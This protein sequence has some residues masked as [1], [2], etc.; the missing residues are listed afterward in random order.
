MLTT[1][2]QNLLRLIHTVGVRPL[3]RSTPGIRKFFDNRKRHK[4]RPC[5]N[6][7]KCRKRPSANKKKHRSRLGLW[8]NSGGKHWPRKLWR[9][10]KH[11]H[12]RCSGSIL[13]WIHPKMQQE[14]TR[15]SRRHLDLHTR[16]QGG[17]SPRL[18][19][20]RSP[21]V[22][23]WTLQSRSR[24]V[25]VRSPMLQHQTAKTRLSPDGRGL[26]GVAVVSEGR[27]A[28]QRRHCGIV[29]RTL[30]LRLVMFLRQQVLQK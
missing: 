24:P 26:A 13:P 12:R 1:C 27:E 28:Q 5:A 2:G 14:T 15:N 29:W 7:K 30:W 17:A 6:K 4:T 18:K 10:S 16:S 11:G 8:S 22:P 3:N 21:P 25:L 9:A 19:Q 20:M 23:L